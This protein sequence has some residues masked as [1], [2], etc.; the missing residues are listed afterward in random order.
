MIMVFI[1]FYALNV[2]SIYA[3][4]TNDFSLAKS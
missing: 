3:Y 1:G 4:S 2:R